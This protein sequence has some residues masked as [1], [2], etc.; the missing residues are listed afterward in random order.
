MDPPR[1]GTSR[2]PA[3][4]GCGESGTQPHQRLFPPGARALGRKQGEGP[5]LRPLGNRQGPPTC[6]RSGLQATPAVTQSAGSSPSSAG[7]EGQTGPRTHR[8]LGR[9][10]ATPDGVFGSPICP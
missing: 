5:E 8:C 7:Q 3:G 1:T 6:L 2:V 9:C 4:K 10:S